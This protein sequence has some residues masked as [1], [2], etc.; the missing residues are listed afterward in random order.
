LIEEKIEQHLA[1]ADGEK[2]RMI[3]KIVRAMVRQDL[4]TLPAE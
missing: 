1:G 4:S 2:K 3:I